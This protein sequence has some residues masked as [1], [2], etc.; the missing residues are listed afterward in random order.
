MA[1]SAHYNSLTEC[2]TWWLNS[3]RQ[4]L[5]LI[6]HPSWYVALRLQKPPDIY[7]LRLLDIENQVR[8]AFY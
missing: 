6:M 7:V 1:I 5:L 4:R 2:C 8:K 3:P